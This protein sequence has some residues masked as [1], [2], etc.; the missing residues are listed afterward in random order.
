KPPR[1]AGVHWTFRDVSVQTFLERLK[2][3]G[4]EVPVK[5]SGQVTVRLSAGAPWRSLWRPSAYE[6]EGDLTS[7]SLTVA[8]FE[9]KSLSLHLVYTDG[10]LQLTDMKFIVPDKDGRDGTV[11]G[12]ARMQARPPGDLTAEL[13]LVQLPL[14]TLFDRVHQLAGHA[15]GTASGRFSGRAPIDGLRNPARW[16]AGGRLTLADVRAVGLPPGQLTLDLRLARGRAAIT[17]LSA[18]LAQARLSGSADLTLAAPYDFTARLRAAV[19]DLAWLKNLDAEFAPPVAV[20]GSFSLSADATGALEPRRVRVRGALTGQQLKVQD[21]HIDRLRVPFEGTLGR[22]RL[23]AIR[24]D[25]YGGQVL[26]NLSLPTEL[27]GNVG[28]GLRVRNVD[29]GRLAA[30]VLGQRQPWRGLASATAQWQTP[31]QRL[32]DP[33][34][35]N[36]QGDFAVGRGNLL[37]IDVSRVAGN[38]AFSNGQLRLTNLA[39]DSALAQLTGSAQLNLTTPFGFATA[40]RIADVDLAPLNRL[41]DELR[42]PVTVGGRAGISARV[43]GT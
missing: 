25:L 36:G 27:A 13:S 6:V 32:L 30:D 24:V 22:V 9:L 42:L 28:A 2:R 16:Q 7:P 10:A 39:V 23:T 38:V 1:R 15:S 31:A 14:A 37:G 40:L 11:S 20:D 35:W 26:A 34:A 43:Q 18:T 41:P 3:F 21:I 5:L 4:V 12:T 8:G 19:P 17:N 33:E 29:V